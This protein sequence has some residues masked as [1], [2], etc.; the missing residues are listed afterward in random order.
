[1]WAV[2]KAHHKIKFPDQHTIMDGDKANKFENITMQF[3]NEW[4]PNPSPVSVVVTSVTVLSQS[5]VSENVKNRNLRSSEMRF[6]QLVV[7]ELE[8]EIEVVGSILPRKPSDDF[9]FSQAVTE[10][11]MNRFDLYTATLRK[12]MLLSND[13]YP[14]TPLEN[15]DVLTPNNDKSNNSNS[16]NKMTLIICILAGAAIVFVSIAFFILRKPGLSSDNSENEYINYQVHSP[17]PS[18]VKNLNDHFPDPILDIDFSK[19]K[20]FTQGNT[21]TPLQPPLASEGTIIYPPSAND[22]PNGLALPTKSPRNLPRPKTCSGLSTAVKIHGVNGQRTPKSIGTPRT[23]RSQGFEMSYN[24]PN[25]PAAPIRIPNT[26]STSIGHEQNIQDD[27][28]SSPT[29]FS[30]NDL[31]NYRYKNLDPNEHFGDEDLSRIDHQMLGIEVKNTM[32]RNMSAGSRNTPSGRTDHQML[33][34]NSSGNNAPFYPNPQSIQSSLS[35]R[36]RSMVTGRTPS[37]SANSFDLGIAN[38][39]LG[40]QFD[41]ASFRSKH[42]NSTRDDDITMVS[43]IGGAGSI[44]HTMS[45]ESGRSSRKMLIQTS[46]A[47]DSSAIGAASRQSFDTRMSVP[48][49]IYDAYAPPGPLGVVIDTTVDGPVI[50]SMKTNSPLIN[51]VHIGDVVVSIDDIDTRSMTAATLTRLMARKSQQPQRKITLRNMDR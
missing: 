48:R 2:L 14:R 19:D 12:G 50:H 22:T 30:R 35:G 23:P 42:S 31:E 36:D 34:R 16:S 10:V 27:G 28:S 20:I 40:D 43:S 41:T 45:G 33:G 11:F 26:R 24:I 37:F 3:I 18:P 38:N 13:V 4:L 39:M 51:L 49:E 9:S 7:P 17:E 5:L 15:Y 44:Q 29:L 6:L 8:V 21:M 46:L 1:M 47:S 32:S 25:Y